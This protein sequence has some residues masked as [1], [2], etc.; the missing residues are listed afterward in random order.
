MIT[1]SK[2]NITVS[3]KGMDS[4]PAA[5]EY[6]EKRASKFAKTV[7]HLTNVHFVL[8]VEKTDFLAQLH[9]VSGDFEARAEAR[10]ESMYAAIDEVTD[11]VLHQTRKHKEKAKSHSGKPHHGQD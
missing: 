3:F 6:C 8:L 5:R 2:L 10:G 7:D 9:L 1:S 4:S 11:K